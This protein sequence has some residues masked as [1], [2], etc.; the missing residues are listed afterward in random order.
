M[1]R[2]GVG[3]SLETDTAKAAREAARRAFRR[4]PSDRFLERRR[5]CAG[6][7][8]QPSSQHLWDDGPDFGWTPAGARRI[9]SAQRESLLIELAGEN[10]A[11]GLLNLLDADGLE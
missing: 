2:A 4:S 5:D 7:R 8:R 11:D 6:P 3:H 10:L 1:F 9:G